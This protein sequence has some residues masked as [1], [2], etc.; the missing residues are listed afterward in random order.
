[1]KEFPFATLLA[2]LGFSIGVALLFS[3]DFFTSSGLDNVAKDPLKAIAGYIKDSGTQAA[4]ALLRG[5]GVGLAVG[6]FFGFA[7]FL[8][9]VLRKRG[10]S[11]TSYGGN[12][13]EIV[14]TR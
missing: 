14:E 8:I 1:M 5:V 12:V 4:K 13:Q 6:I 9:D 10:I 7:G 11:Q 2:I 3:A